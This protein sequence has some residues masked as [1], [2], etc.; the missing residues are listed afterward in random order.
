MQMLCRLLDQ[1]IARCIWLVLALWVLSSPTHATPAIPESQKPQANPQEVMQAAV[2]KWVAR[3]Q[4]VEAEQVELAPLDARLKVRACDKPLTLDLPFSSPESVRVRCA[5]PAWQLYVRVS[6]TARPMQP[7][8]QAKTERQTPAPVAKRF[9]LVA[10]QRLQHGTT[11]NEAHVSRVEVDTSG[12]PVNALESLADIRYA[13][14]VRDVPAGSPIRSL[15]IRPLVLV[16]RGQLV[17][18]SVGQPQAFQISAR[19]EALQDGRLGEQVKL[20]NP[21]SGRQLTGLV[22][23]P[24]QVRGL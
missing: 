17:M 16:K 22:Q 2:K 3:E 11:L 15:D 23:G 7:V 10:T 13:E 1:V 19:V 6:L 12:V 14:L 20:K 21:E 9:M 8:A 4:G 18:M 24:N 5:Q